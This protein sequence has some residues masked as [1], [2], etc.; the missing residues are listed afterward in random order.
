MRVDANHNV[1]GQ[2][3]SGSNPTPHGYKAQWG[4]HTDV[5]TGILLLT[6]RYFDPARG[7]FLT[8]PIG[9]WLRMVHILS[10]GYSDNVLLGAV[11]RCYAGAAIGRCFNATVQIYQ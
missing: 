2:L 1:W 10:A 8:R 3:M 7:R 5:E 9:V 4:Y 6:H 11:E